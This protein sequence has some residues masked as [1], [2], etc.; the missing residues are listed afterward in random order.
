MLHNIKG[1]D[2]TLTPKIKKYI[3]RRT[4][5]LDKFFGRKSGARVDIEIQFLKNE[6]KMYRAEGTVHDH[7]FDGDFRAEAA[8]ATTNEAIDIMV[9]ELVDEFARAKK[10]IIHDK[11]RGAA[12]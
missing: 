9:G 4:T 8:G 3:E 10:R 5:A 6:D 1:T 11:R 7:G 2:L 12:R